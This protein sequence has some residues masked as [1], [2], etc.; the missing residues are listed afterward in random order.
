MLREGNG[1]LQRR[2]KKACQVPLI[3]RRTWNLSFLR[4]CLPRTAGVAVAAAQRQPL[5]ARLLK[6]R[7]HARPARHAGEDAQRTPAAGRV[8]EDA[9][10]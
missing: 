4:P 3:R 5:A 6:A 10:R 9:R 2:V 1:G 8:L 7:L